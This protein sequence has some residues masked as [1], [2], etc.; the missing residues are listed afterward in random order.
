MVFFPLYKPNVDCFAEHLWSL[1]KGN[2]M[3][4]SHTHSDL[5][6]YDL[7]HCSNED[8][9]SS[10]LDFHFTVLMHPCLFSLPQTN[11]TNLLSRPLSELGQPYPHLIQDI[12]LLLSI[13]PPMLLQFIFS[14]SSP[15]D[16]KL[17]FYFSSHRFQPLFCFY[18]VFLV[19]ATCWFSKFQENIATW[20]P[21]NLVTVQ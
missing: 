7:L 13:Q 9:F 5:Y 11:L 10:S 20:W 4:P 17:W 18:V 15:G 2:Q 16:L 6:V 1:I 19:F 8:K 14:H 12:L 3:P 21:N